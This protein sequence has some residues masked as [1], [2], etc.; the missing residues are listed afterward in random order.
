[1][2]IINTLTDMIMKKNMFLLMALVAILTLAACGSDSDS[3]GISNIVPSSVRLTGAN[4]RGAKSLAIA[5]KVSGSRSVLATRADGEAEQVDALYKVSADGSFIEV[6]YT[7]NV[8]T[9]GEGDAAAVMQQVQANLRIKPNFIFKLGD[10][11]LWLAN[12]Y[13]YVPGYADMEEDAVKKALMKIVGDFNEAHH[14]SHGAHY[15][16]RKSDGAFFEWNVADGA[17]GGM[18]PMDDGYNPQ[19]M[20]NGWF[21]AVGNTLYVR[22]YGWMTFHDYRFYNNQRVLRL[23][24]NGSTISSQPVTTGEDRIVGILPVGNNFCFISEEYQNIGDMEGYAPYIYFT[25]TGKKVKLQ[26]PEPTHVNQTPR[27]IWSAVSLGG[28]LY[29]VRNYHSFDEDNNAYDTMGYYS[30]NIDEANQTATVGEKIA[31]AEA[32]VEFENDRYLYIG[33]A[34]DRTSYTYF[35]EVGQ[36]KQ[37]A[38]DPNTYVRDRQICTFDAATG[39]I[40]TRPLPAHYN[41]RIDEYVDGIACT[42]ATDKGFYLC[43]LSKDEAEYITLDWSL[44]PNLQSKVTSMQAVHYEMGNTSLKYRCS[45]N[46]G[47]TLYAWVPISGENRGKVVVLGETDDIQSNYDIKVVIDL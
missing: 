34:S 47:R 25:R 22:E 32:S 37:S 18:F 27:V 16:I 7:F 44:A 29:A 20:V 31:E 10:D 36:Y 46:D 26:T 3:S 19:S 40:K 24:I 11:Y 14:D 15:I 39:T 8:E 38:N 28:K 21:H 33:Y 2:Y 17:P 45:T 30:V 5:S 42:E 1:M 9:E 23:N 35:A 43:D 13:Y 6:T 41:E 12:C 4:I